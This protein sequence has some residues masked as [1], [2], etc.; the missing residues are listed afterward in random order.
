M[1]AVLGPQKARALADARR[2]K[3]GKNPEAERLRREAAHPHPVRPHRVR[4]ARR[5]GLVARWQ[6]EEAAAKRPMHRNHG[7][8]ETFGQWLDRTH[9][10][11]GGHGAGTGGE[12]ARRVV[13]DFQDERCESPRALRARKAGA[14]SGQLRGGLRGRR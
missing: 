11:H 14:Q 4:G 1:R 9:P 7:D 10:A 12:G 8:G 2:D 5:A 6:A 13:R 3:A